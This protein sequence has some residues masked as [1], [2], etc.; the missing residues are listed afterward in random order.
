MNNRIREL[1]CQA[2]GTKKHV[3]AVWQFYDH[4]LEKFVELI[5]QECIS[6]ATDRKEWVENQQVYDHR[7]ASWNRAGL[8]QS[9]D[10]IDSI[11][12]HFGI[13]EADIAD[14]DPLF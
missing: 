13:Y 3:P 10:I 14:Q 2:E 12:L 9:Q 8:H 6:V 1:A 5:V 7:D 11:K 4:E